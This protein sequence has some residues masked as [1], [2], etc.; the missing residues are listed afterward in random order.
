MV[1]VSHNGSPEGRA[2]VA[3]HAMAQRQQ[4]SNEQACIR[5]LIA[6]HGVGLVRPDDGWVNR[7]DNTVAPEAYPAHH[8]RPLA[9]GARIALGSPVC[10]DVVFGKYRICEVVETLYHPIS[11]LRYRFEEIV[12]SFEI[13]RAA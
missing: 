5:W 7:S 11:G 8:P 10:S 9:R 6:H 3:S 2:I 1:R 12:P 4:W 13:K